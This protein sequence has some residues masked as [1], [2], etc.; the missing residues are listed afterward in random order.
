LATLL[1]SDPIF[2][3]HL[4]PPGHPERPERLRAIDRALA[5]E[6]FAALERRTAPAPVSEETIAFAHDQRY[7][8]LIRDNVPAQGFTRLDADTT[9]SPQ[10]Y[11]A[12]SRAVGAAAMAVDA[13]MRGSVA[14]AFCAM[15]PPGHHAEP[16]QAM[17][18]CLFANAVIAARHAQRA[19]GAARVAIVDFDVHHGNGT[20]ACVWS[21]PTI[22]YASTHQMPLYPGTGAASERGVGNVFNA[23]LAPGAGGVEFNQAYTSIILP[24]IESFAPELIIISAGF[25][26][27]WRDPLASLNLE[28]EDYASATRM[29]MDLADRHAGSRIVSLLEGGYD[30]QSLADS[31]AAHVK[32]LMSV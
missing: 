13:V 6:T 26:A 7:I 29:L 2:L 11:V 15:R 30:L 19:H 4:V 9:L 17:G 1:V 23:P 18:F 31:V 21:D 14:N 10:S 16:S 22:L 24:A 28:E 25:D 32:T 20:Q 3:E 27:H 8:A 12:A 5:D